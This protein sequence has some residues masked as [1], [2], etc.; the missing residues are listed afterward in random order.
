MTDTIHCSFTFSTTTTNRPGSPLMF[1][2]AEFADEAEILIAS[3][4]HL[5]STGESQNTLVQLVSKYHLDHLGVR[6]RNLSCCT[7]T[8]KIRGSIN[9]IKLVDAPCVYEPSS[10]NWY[11]A[12]APFASA[13]RNMI[14]SLPP[15]RYRHLQHS[16]M[17]Q[18]C[19]S[20]P[21]YSG[22]RRIGGP[23]P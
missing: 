12:H 23:Y 21:A 2:P 13:P 18:A 10:S 19:C 5:D 22:L 14:N 1:V 3:T 9:K 6:W 15:R 4:Q 17:H 8:A 7:E 11:H 16:P 20:R